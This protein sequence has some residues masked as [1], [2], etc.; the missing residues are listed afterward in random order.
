MANFVIFQEGKREA[1]VDVSCF[2]SIT[3]S[4]SVMYNKNRHKLAKKSN[5]FWLFL[6]DCTCGKCGFEDPECAFYLGLLCKDKS[7]NKDPD[8]AA[9]HCINCPEFKHLCG[10][11]CNHCG[12]K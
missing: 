2:L 6:G 7:G 3:N 11:T 5:I 9:N 1:F 10:I 8:F 12:E 4:H